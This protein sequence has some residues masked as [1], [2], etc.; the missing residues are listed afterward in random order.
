MGFCVGILILK[1]LWNTAVLC[2]ERFDTLD[3]RSILLKCWSMLGFNTL[4]TRNSARSLY[5]CT[6]GTACAGGYVLLI[7]PVL[8]EFTPSVLLILQVLE[9]SG[10]RHYCCNTLNTR[11]TKKTLY[12]EHVW[13]VVPGYVSSCPSCR[14][15]TRFRYIYVCMHTQDLL[16]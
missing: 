10:R 4:N 5:G 6:A 13:N 1:F 9:Y 2:S 7:L 8:R 11:S 14:W 12:S 15:T 16:K 3:T